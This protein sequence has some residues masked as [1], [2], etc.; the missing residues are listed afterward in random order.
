MDRNDIE[1]QGVDNGTSINH[2]F[3]IKNS[4]AFQRI[5]AEL[6][7][8]VKLSLT[9][10]TNFV[11]NYE[12]P[13]I[14]NVFLKECFKTQNLYNSTIDIDAV[15]LQHGSPGKGNSYKY[16]DELIYGSF[17]VEQN[18]DLD[19]PIPK[20]D[21]QTGKR[22]RNS[23][24]FVNRKEAIL[25][26]CKDKIL[27]IRNLDYAVDF[28]DRETPGEVGA[29]ALNLLDNFRNPT[30]KNG[31][32]LLL[33]TNAPLKLP[34]QIRT[35]KISPVS[36]DEANHIINSF[37]YLFRNAKYDISFSASQTE[38]I[39][40][41]LTGLTYTEA[42]DVFGASLSTSG[43]NSKSKIIDPIKLI[44]ALRKN[45]NSKFMEKGFGLTQLTSRPWED[46]ICPESSKFTW[47]VKK[48]LRDFNEVK[49][50][51][52]KS[53]N[54]VKNGED[55]SK[56]EDLIERIETRMPHVMVLYG[57]GG[58]GKSAFPVHLAGL[59]GFDVWDFNV[60]SVHSKWIG[61]G[62]EQAR[63][64]I[65]AIMSSSHV[66]VR[67]D[68][69]DRAM[70]S[71]GG[72]AEGMHEAHKQVES[73]FMSWLQNGQEENQFMK[74]NIFVVLTTNHK[75]NI[76]GPMLR[77]GRVD[78]VIDIDN[79]DSESMKETLKTTARRMGN[80]G[81]KVLGFDNQK[82]LQKAID[83]LDLDQLSE[84]CTMKGF[85]VRDVE[86]LVMEMAAHDYYF[87]LG[88][89]GLSWNTKNFVEVLE[90]S[91]GS[92]KDDDSTGELVLGD[93]EIFMR[94]DDNKD[95]QTEIDFDKTGNKIQNGF[96]QL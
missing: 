84:L 73:E 38:Q 88:K 27:I 10:I 68:E 76:T 54:A 90:Y 7:I 2:S 59:L 75:E 50:L 46:Y 24:G 37:T 89:E 23:N 87:K 69:Y 32:N 64:S 41:K 18:A 80:R 17:E 96:K 28:C 9:G 85:T 42:G 72:G 47:D 39:I 29:K 60:N 8:A 5:K 57:K 3:L 13:H 79:F 4:E 81:I 86:T 78:L 63:K 56:Y 16:L 34:F 61:Q 62:S 35:V 36:R 70:G 91:Q 26:E 43:V 95:M 25:G 53:N 21:P 74:K 11:V 51:R 31:C 12:D 65:D 58:T 20:I 94:R 48:L 6:Q 82:D 83:S 45:I 14:V 44:S 22:K 66:I 1:S 30:V 19:I 33:I 77:S 52:E 55:E 92:M 49:I 67:I 93:R 15:E 71:T 40:R